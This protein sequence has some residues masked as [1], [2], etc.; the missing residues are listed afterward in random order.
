MYRLLLLVALVGLAPLALAT[1]STRKNVLMI[2]IDDMWVVDDAPPTNVLFI[3]HAHTHPQRR[4]E[5]SPYGFDYMHTPNIQR[6][7]DRGTVFQ[8]AYV[9]VRLT[10]SPSSPQVELQPCPQTRTPLPKVAL[11]M[12]SR[13]ALLTTRR[14]D[15]TKNWL[16]AHNEWFRDCGGPSCPAHVCDP[17]CGASLT[18][19]PQMFKDKLGY[20]VKGAGKI[21][22]EGTPPL[23]SAA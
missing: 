16:I 4:P 19:L 14:P 23:D 6:L 12:P 11:C 20:T 18:T 15:T 10:S 5:L 13:T 8:R 22:H 2:A 1:S 21:F 9:Q 17:G 3:T 7:A